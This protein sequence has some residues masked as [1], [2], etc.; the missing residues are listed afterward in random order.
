LCCSYVVVQEQI[1]NINDS[2][3]YLKI[4]L[5]NSEMPKSVS[6]TWKFSRV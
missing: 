5:K 4:S 2:G 1:A 3:N 6:Q